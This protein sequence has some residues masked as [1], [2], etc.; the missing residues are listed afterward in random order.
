MDARDPNPVN[1]YQAS[2]SFQAHSLSNLLE[3]NGIA[4]HITGATASDGFEV[5]EIMLWVSSVNAAEARYSVNLHNDWNGKP[6][7]HRTGT[8]QTRTTVAR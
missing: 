1:V 5:N 4:V 8:T 7:L 2:D 3:E 6:L